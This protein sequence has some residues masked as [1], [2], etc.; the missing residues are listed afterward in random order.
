MLTRSRWLR[1][2]WAVWLLAWVMP[3][4]AQ[5]R[6]NDYVHEDSARFSV[7][8][9]PEDAK[10]VQGLWS[11][12]RERVPLVEQQLGLALADTV[13]F[14]VTPSEKEWYRLTAGAPLWANG[15]AYAQRG[16]AVLKSPRFGL[17]YGPLPTTA[18]HEY[19]HLLL[20]AG[21]PGADIPR[22]LNEGLAQV[23]AGQLHYMDDALLAR[24]AAAGRLH[25][26]SAI[27][28]MMGMNALDARQAYAESAVAVQFLQM[29]FGMAGISNLIHE[30]R[31]GEPYEESFRRIFGE[32]SGAFESDYVRYV[33]A[34]FRISFFADTELWV[35]LA[36]VLAVG[37]AG[38]AVWLR[39]RRTVQ[40]WREEE[41]GE[42]GA[43]G[44][45]TVPPYTIKYTIVRGR[46]H[47]SDSD[48]DSPPDENLPYDPPAPGA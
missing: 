9:C 32:G 16:V 33:Q 46:L 29:R 28:G 14:V 34:N 10:V 47:E 20:E 23:L 48:D 35:S 4:L 3:V 19:V 30:L 11:E 36:F 21:A 8:F 41:Q 45:S 7:W 1:I 44:G 37:A 24:A 40:R 13:M 26:F 12:L 38:L 39:R 43:A 22:W 18:V 2:P 6:A 17:P 27:E 15:I 25:S 42:R 5:T 31:N